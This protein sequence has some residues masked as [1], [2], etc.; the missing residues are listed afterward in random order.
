MGGASVLLEDAIW[1][2]V[3]A[4]QKR[5]FSAPAQ[6]IA[7]A[8]KHGQTDCFEMA[9]FCSGSSCPGLAYRNEQA[10]MATLTEP[11]ADAINFSFV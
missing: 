7:A 8:A 4:A 2:G 9:K 3:P 1:R 11:S 6:I 10:Y 5:A